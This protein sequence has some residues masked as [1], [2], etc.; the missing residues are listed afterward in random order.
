MGALQCGACPLD[1][2]CDVIEPFAC[3]VTNVLSSARYLTGLTTS[4]LIRRLLLFH[5]HIE[6]NA[7]GNAYLSTW[8]LT[9]LFL[10]LLF[11]DI[12][13]AFERDEVHM[14][15][16]CRP[17]KS[18]RLELLKERKPVSR[19]HVDYTVGGAPIGFFLYKTSESPDVQDGQV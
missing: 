14:D 11:K 3:A 13:K 12:P 7:F 19:A 10:T 18:R 9:P 16:N 17:D 1:P 8:P 6:P 4:G 15:V 2:F 5:C